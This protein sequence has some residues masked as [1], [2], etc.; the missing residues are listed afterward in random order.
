MKFEYTDFHKSVSD[1]ELI[2]DLKATAKTLNALS[3]SMKEYDENGQYSSSAV[4]RRFG[5]WNKALSIAELDY[6]CKT[7]SNIELFEKIE[8]SGWGALTASESGR[9][10]GMIRKRN[11]QNKKKE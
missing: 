4:S 3:L 8:K 9:I 7:F 11:T 6:K 2:A 1:E 10:G 5:T